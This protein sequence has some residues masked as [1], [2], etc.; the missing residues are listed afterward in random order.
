MLLLQT[1]RYCPSGVSLRMRGAAGLRPPGGANEAPRCC[2]IPFARR[3]FISAFRS[4]QGQ[5][6]F[7]NPVVC[8]SVGLSHGATAAQRQF[9][10]IFHLAAADG[11][12]SGTEGCFWI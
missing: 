2:A 1:K 3:A 4:A 12:R 10:R 5:I 7:D 6:L 11:I 8:L 9:E